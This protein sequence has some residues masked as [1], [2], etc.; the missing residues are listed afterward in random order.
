MRAERARE[1]FRELALLQ[2]PW[3]ALET[4]FCSPLFPEREFNGKKAILNAGFMR[5]GAVALDSLKVSMS[6]SKCFGSYSICHQALHLWIHCTRSGAANQNAKRGIGPLIRS[7]KVHQ[8]RCNRWWQ[9]MGNE[10]KWILQ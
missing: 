1:L 2:V 5:K 4:G 6:I 10:M 8:V 9:L 7:L 3:A